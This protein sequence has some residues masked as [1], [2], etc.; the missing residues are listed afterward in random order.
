ML[1]SVLLG[2]VC[3]LV[4]GN[5]ALSVLI[6]GRRNS[7]AADQPSAALD[8]LEK[9]VRDELARARAESA[10]NS[11][12][13]REELQASIDRWSD[14]TTRRQEAQRTSVDE[15]IGRLSVMTG[16]KLDQIRTESTAGSDRSTKA[17]G[18]SLE[19]FNR[20]VLEG[21]S[22]QF[23]VF[24]NRLDGLSKSVETKIESVRATVDENLKSISAENT[25]QLELVRATVDE[26][27]QGT[28][29]RR[30]GESF[31]Q[32]SDRLEQVYRGL[33][34]M[35]VLATG[36]GDLK[37]VLTNVKSRGTW[38][39]VQLE[40]L[41]EQV[42]AR[43]QY[44][45]NVATK[46]DANRVEFAIKFPGK[47]DDSPGPLW[48]PIDAKFPVEDYHRLVDAQ[49]RCDADAAEI[50]YRQLEVR[51]KSC[52]RDICEKYISPPMT[53]DFAVLFLPTEGLYAE[54]L[55]RP[56]L[57]ES[58]QRDC[59]VV[60]AGPTT[61]WAILS[62]LQMG[63]K[64][65]SIQKQTSAIATTL[66]AVKTEWGKYN[67]LLLG[68]QKKLQ[69]ASNTIDKAQTRSRAIGR[70]LGDFDKLPEIEATAVL[71]LTDVPVVDGESM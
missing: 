19:S 33:G 70:K 55:R 7:P 60:L 68:L 4:A 32:V 71:R 17:V 28:L 20:S 51:I 29:E 16:Q 42:L 35:Q 23:D 53:T 45:K 57:S 15:L 2:L 66:S 39:E 40:A 52:A 56:G 27:L 9:L 64:T 14:A 48:L 67:E 41:L 11:R 54:V 22:R 5:L 63:F 12:I 26:K 30:L 24:T 46:G 36:V 18:T 10:A 3:V 43:D 6:F 8:R 1:T 59:R 61:L 38:G 47:T 62:S 69:A 50:A 58:V 31:T 65:L 44:E 49:D 34:E 37:K 25:R 13:G 21:M